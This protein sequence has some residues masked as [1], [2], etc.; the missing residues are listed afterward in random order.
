MFHQEYS[1]GAKKKALK[2]DRK[3]MRHTGN[4]K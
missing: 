3:D 1:L 4:Q 2:E